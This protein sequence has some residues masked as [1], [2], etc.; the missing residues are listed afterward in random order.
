MTEN[1]QRRSNVIVVQT[2][3]G[4][5]RHANTPQNYLELIGYDDF[6]S[7][8]ADT[9]TLESD[10]ESIVVHTTGNKNIFYVD[11]GS[12]IIPTHRGTVTRILENIISFIEEEL[13]AEEV[14]AGVSTRLNTY[15]DE[16]KSDYTSVISVTDINAFFR[17]HDKIQV[18][19]DGITIQEKYMIQWNGA[20]AD[21]TTTVDSY[22]CEIPEFQPPPREIEFSSRNLS[23]V[24]SYFIGL[25]T[26][27]N[28]SI[29]T[30]RN[31]E[32]RNFSDYD[33]SN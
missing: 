25:T 2:E 29:E 23:E 32:K 28:D 30:N 1:I 16:N 4:I 20:V 7:Q 14:D 5:E 11:I 27:L 9:I 15:A 17:N 12:A 21:L 13:T 33:I 24:D 8:D 6:F 3:N 22:V 26:V 10:T 18:S 19:D 31:L